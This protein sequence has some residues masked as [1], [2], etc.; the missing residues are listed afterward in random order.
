MR[1]LTLSRD[2]EKDEF[3]TIFKNLLVEAL[4]P[5][6]FSLPDD[7]AGAIPTNVFASMQP[8]HQKSS[9]LLEK[10][11]DLFKEYDSITAE[12]S[13]MQRPQELATKWEEENKK[14][15][16]IIQAGKVAVGAEIQTMLDH[17]DRLAKKKIIDPDLEDGV[18]SMLRMGK[19][20]DQEEEAQETEG[21]GNVARGVEK[22]F[23]QLYKVIAE[24]IE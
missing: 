8:L 11:A 6:G 19:G 5:P 21:W 22:G 10:S 18:E 7:S 17:H 1:Q 4:I 2:R 14:A 16:R 3:E 9:F 15:V 23:N 20:K 13:A 12:A 24:E